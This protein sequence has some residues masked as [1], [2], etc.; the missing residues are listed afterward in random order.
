MQYES[1]STLIQRL[2]EAGS[3][4]FE[5]WIIYPDEVQAVV[6]A[7]ISQRYPLRRLQVFAGRLDNDDRACFDLDGEPG[8]VSVVHDFAGE[9]W[10]Q[11]VKFADER[12]W[13]RSAIEDFI[14]F[15]PGD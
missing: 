6:Q 12:A 10:E 4:R 11:V 8:C 1:G 3:T 13:L 2:K 7:G 14:E 5:P 9:G 15:E